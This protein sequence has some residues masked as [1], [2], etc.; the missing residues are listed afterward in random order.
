MEENSNTHTLILQ[1]LAQS[2]Q[3][4]AKISEN[5][6]VNTN[7]TQNIKARVSEI[8]ANVKEAVGLGQKTNGRVTQ[9]EDWCKEAQKVIENTTRIANETYTNYKN[10]KT[11]IWAVIGVLLFLG[12]TIITLAIMAIDSKIDRKIDFILSE[13]E[14]ENE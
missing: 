1:Q 12:G 13:Y 14:I 11:R 8:Q 4:L 9:L 10:D 5:L 3:Q 7:E 2:S 6:A